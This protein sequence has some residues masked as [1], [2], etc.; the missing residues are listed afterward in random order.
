MAGYDPKIFIRN[1]GEYTARD[2]IFTTSYLVDVGEVRDVES[3]IDHVEN[4]FDAGT[5]MRLSGDAQTADD[6]LAL[7]GDAAPGVLT[8]SNPI[9]TI[10]TAHD[11]Q[12]RINEE[13]DT[14]ATIATTVTAHDVIELIG[15]VDHVESVATV[16]TAHTVSEVLS[17]IDAV[18]TAATTV[19]PNPVGE[20]VGFIDI[21][22]TVEV[23]TTAHDVRLEEHHIDSVATK[24]Y[25]VTAWPVQ[26][27][28][29]LVDTVA[30]I[31]TTLT[32]GE[33]GEIYFEPA[34]IGIILSGDA[35]DTP[36]DGLELSGDAGPGLLIAP[37]EGDTSIETVGTT[38]TAH[39]VLISETDIIPTSTITVTAH[40]VLLS[41]SDVINSVGTI[42]TVHPVLEYWLDSVETAS[43]AVTAHDVGEVITEID[44]IGL[45]GDAVDVAGDA[46][47]L[48][49]DEVGVLLYGFNSYTDVVPTVSVVV[50][51]HAVATPEMTPVALSGDAQSGGDELILSGDETGSL[52]TITE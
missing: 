37:P 9:S 21:V 11:V 15:E 1:Y 17:L 3:L 46:L 50:T 31:T 23:V 26:E 16:V 43:V 38:V 36:N 18:P 48:S 40:D 44:K 34:E 2:L 4:P 49:G 19:T 8:L 24:T 42:V 22:P 47:S 7:S 35:K 33:F 39:D 20:V 5:E 13:T 27:I 28:A 29:G 32:L 45:S 6:S 52:M 30:T 41:E 12:E 25:S 51:P 14:V 10:V